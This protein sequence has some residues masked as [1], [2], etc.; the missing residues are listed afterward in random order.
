MWVNVQ[1]TAALNIAHMVELNRVA[2]IR[3]A[4]GVHSE[5]PKTYDHGGKQG[6]QVHTKRPTFYRSQK[7][8]QK[9]YGKRKS[10]GN[11]ACLRFGDSAPSQIPRNTATRKRP[12]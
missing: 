12:N 3:N 9:S 10:E 7:I 5:K 1:A 2:K 8:A 4:R 6:P 11:G